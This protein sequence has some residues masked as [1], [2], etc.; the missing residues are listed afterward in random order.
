MLFSV[1]NGFSAASCRCATRLLVS[2]AIRLGLL[3]AV[4]FGG[5]V[6]PGSAADEKTVDYRKHV[7]PIFTKYCT[8]CHDAKEANGE[9]NLAGYQTLMRGGENGKVIVPGK[10]DSSRMIRLLEKKAE[11]FMPPEGE[12]GPTAKEIAVLKA[13][14]KLGAKGPAG[15]APLPSLRNIPHIKIVGDPRKPIHAVAYSPNGKQIAVA[16]FG[17]VEIVSAVDGKRLAMLTGHTGQVNGVGFSTDGN[18]LFAAAGEPG[19]F[20]EVTLWNVAEGKRLRTLRGHSD[21][22]YA[23]AMNPPGTILATGSYDQKIKLWDTKTGAELRTLPGHNGAVFDLAFHPSGKFLASASDDFTVKLW[24]VKTGRRLDTRNEP[25]KAQSTLDFSLDG[26]L[27]AAGG[28]DHRIRIWRMTKRGTAKILHSLFAH[29]ASILK[30]AF[31]PDGRRLVSSAEDRTIKIW[32]TAEF[33][34]I[35][36][37][38][39]QPDWAAALTVSPDS[40]TLLVGR[41]DGTLAAYPLLRKPGADN[42]PRPITDAAIAAAALNTS[43]QAEKPAE[44]SE[45]E[46][47]NLP[48]QAT[49]LPVPAHADGVLLSADPQQADVDLYRFDAKQSEPWIIETR[50]ARNKSPADTKI[51]ILYADGRPVEQLLMRA[52]RDSYITFRPINSSQTNVRVKNWEEMG[53]NQYLY[54]NGEVCKLLVMPRGP[55]SGLVLFAV[56]GKRQCYFDTSAIAHARDEPVYIVQPYLSGTKIADNGLPLFPLYYANDDGGEQKLGSDSRLTF[57]PPA[58]GSYLVRVSDVRGFGGKAYKYRLT[59]RRPIPDFDLTIGGKDATVGSG[60][61]QRLT[62]KLNRTDSFNGPVQIDITGLPAGYHVPSPIVVEAGHLEARGVIN[63]SPELVVPEQKQKAGKTADWSK[64]VVTATATI[65]DRKVTKQ[66][67]NLGTIKLAA[68]PKVL[69]RLSADRPQPADA[70]ATPA[71]ELVIAPGTTITAMLSI[72]RNGFDGELRF[73]ID[74]LPHGVIVDNI[75]LSGIMVREGETQRQIFL[76]AADWVKNTTRMIHA[77]AQ[78][79]GKQASWPIKLQVR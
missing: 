18:T 70:K 13:W 39:K 24:E 79:Q 51:E 12:K 23:A 7:V 65:G 20:G 10:P 29:E 21:S 42:A 67:G 74:N 28:V 45:A 2:R 32:D 52:V 8:G 57:S 35:V 62:F 19:L 47:N 48:A 4:L 43:D 30:V 77:V 50:A 3:F 54:M 61:G 36:T 25:T 66:L 37:L 31:S 53:L 26:N 69:V 46:P 9:L 55:D 73:D 38:E 56:N 59:I 58:D 75:G 72:E 11:P 71:A 1:L 34:Q 5:W 16:R 14:I 63:A 44:L 68:R 78:G 33:T 22:L 49:P 6:S 60:S 27:L 17:A 41:M 40:K 64:V 15:K 76:T